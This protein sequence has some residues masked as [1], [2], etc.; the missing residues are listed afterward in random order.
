MTGTEPTLD[1]RD[2]PS[3]AVAITRNT[4]LIVVNYG[5]HE[6]LSRNLPQVPQPGVDVIVVDSFSTTIERQ[7]MVDLAA[8]RQWQLLTPNQN[9]GFGSGCNLGAQHAI[10]RGAEVLVFVNPDA[11]LDAVSR[12]RLVSAVAADDKTVVA[13]RI[14]RPDGSIW[15]SGTTDLYLDT[16]TMR[17]TRKRT[18]GK[19]GREPR[20]QTW[21]SGA[22]FAIS[23]RLWADIGGFDADYFLYWEDVDLSWRV[24]ERGGSLLTLTDAVA[25]HDEGGTHADGGSSRARSN[26]YYYFNIRNRMLFAR[27][28]LD[29]HDQRRWQRTS[30]VAARAIVL[31][32]G[33]RQLVTGFGPWVAAARGLRDAVHAGR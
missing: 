32:G 25:V 21:L 20:V 6:L 33:R 13:P 23:T 15:A 14:E 8:A 28:H 17:A 18:T 5:S 27:K 24:H 3:D 2:T 22:C 11:S 29:P 31:Q 26:T 19:G 10:D 30:L 16:G 7:A 9:V 4:S 1:A 12:N